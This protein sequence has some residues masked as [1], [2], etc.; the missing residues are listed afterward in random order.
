MK[1]RHLHFCREGL[2]FVVIMAFI[3]G[4]AIMRQI[5]L[6]MLLFGLMAGPLLFNLFS[7]YLMLPRLQ[8]RRRLPDMV[9][10]GDPLVVELTATNIFARGAAWAV[11]VD[12]RVERVGDHSYAAAI[13][14]SVMF[15]HVPA[16]DSRK[17]S[18]RGVLT[19]RGRYRFGPLGLSTRFPLGLVRCYMPY[20]ENSGDQEL[21]VLPRVGELTHRW[22]KMR[23]EAYQRTRSPHQRRGMLEGDFHNLRPWRTG[24]SRRWIHWRTTARQGELMV[25]QFEQQLQRD[26]ALI[27]ELWQPAQPNAH[28]TDSVELAVSFAASICTE[29]CRRGGCQLVFGL[30]ATQQQFYSGPASLALQEDALTTLALYQATPKDHLPQVMI[31]CLDLIPQGT[32]IVLVST[33][34]VDLNDQQRFATFWQDS[35]GRSLAGRVLPIDASSG[36]LQHYFQPT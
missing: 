2:Y 30:S 3:V 22:T 12:D 34:P 19:R 23:E 5:N 27:V 7:V 8:L 24:D 28:Q 29:M 20:G 9:A 17:L 26:L 4:G 32:Q 10:A 15:T 16:G 25:R 33:R 36:E 31:G 11:V 13:T 35:R 21:L 6:L 14:S 1:R 18:Y